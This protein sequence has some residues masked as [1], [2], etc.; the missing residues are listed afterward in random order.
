V[1]TLAHPLNRPRLDATGKRVLRGY[2]ILQPR[3]SPTLPLMGE[4]TLLNRL[5]SGRAGT[6][7]YTTAVPSVYH[8]LF[9]EGSYTG[10]GIYDVDAF[11]ACLEGRLPENRLLSHD[12]LEGSLA[13]SGLASDIEFFE[14]FDGHH[15]AAM[16][17]RHRWARGDWQLLPWILGYGPGRGVRLGAVARWK[18]IDNLRRSLLAP[19]TFLTLVAA[20]LLPMSRALA[21]SGL[22]LAGLALPQLLNV[23]VAE[24]F[25]RRPN[26]SLLRHWQSLSQ[27]LDAGL[28]KFV[29]SVA[30]LPVDAWAMAD[31]VFRTLFRLFMSRRRLLEWTSSAHARKELVRTRM[32]FFRL[33]KAGPIAGAESASWFSTRCRPPVSRRLPASASRISTRNT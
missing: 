29:F 27:E 30:M 31:A 15:Q 33:F 11:D 13:R 8:D 26:I 6:D 3:I 10:K 18:M 12:L 21:W 24:L 32:A 23:L 9:D 19:A 16:G 7:P 20:C 25:P 14:E 22:A 17:C 28:L 1:G 5:A 4:G 2:G